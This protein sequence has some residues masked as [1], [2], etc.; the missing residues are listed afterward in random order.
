M[1][2][3]LARVRVWVKNIK[4]MSAYLTFPRTPRSARFC[5]C[6]RSI[7]CD[8]PE[9]S[10]ECH[11]GQAHSITDRITL[12]YLC[13][14]ITSKHADSLYSCFGKWI[15]LDDKLTTWLKYMDIP[16][17][18]LCNIN[19]KQ[20]MTSHFILPL[21]T[22]LDTDA[23]S[24]QIRVA[25]LSFSWQKNVHETDGLRC[26]RDGTPDHERWVRR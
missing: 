18:R 23:F 10:D 6:S 19:A 7:S 15:R 8:C 24:H 4:N 16:F 5:F 9:D 12:V 22:V 13:H 14:Q 21:C 1:N 20:F 11:I 17:Q 2:C 25:V 26:R 3:A